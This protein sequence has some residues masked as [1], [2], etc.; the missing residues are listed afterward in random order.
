MV[1]FMLTLQGSPNKDDE[2]HR[3]LIRASTTN[4][5][6]DYHVVFTER[7]E[8]SEQRDW[9]EAYSATVE[10]FKGTKSI[11]KFR[12]SSL[13]NFLPSNDKPLEWKYAVVEATCAFPTDLRNRFYT[14]KRTTRGDGTTP[15]L[16]LHKKVPTVNISSERAA[17]MT[18]ENIIRMLADESK[19]K[20]YNQFATNILVHSGFQQTCRGSA[21]CLT[22]HPDNANAFFSL[23]ADG[24]E[25]TLELNRGI[26]D[27]SKRL[28][29]CY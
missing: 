8:S 10:V 23:I 14:W 1:S 4:E 19:A 28:S 3:N 18:L 16:R 15:C 9:K 17:E 11:G 2:Q 13:P 7:I 21:G 26:E 5:Q 25:G 12:G 27:K 29:Y 6:A 20:R 22:I 24:L